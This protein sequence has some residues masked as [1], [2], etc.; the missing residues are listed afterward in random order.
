[1]LDSCEKHDEPVFMIVLREIL[2]RIK[3]I[4]GCQSCSIRL[5]E[6]VDFPFYVYYGYP[7][8]FIKKENSLL[9]KMRTT[10]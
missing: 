4:S 8:F 6:D 3:E 7:D 10:I 5:S 2:F 9:I 1:M